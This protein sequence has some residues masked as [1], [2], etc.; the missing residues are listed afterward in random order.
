MKY[1][2]A[3]FF[4]GFVCSLSYSQ[5]LGFVK[6]KNKGKFYLYWG[7]NRGAYTDS[8]IHFK[9]SDYDF[10]LHDVKAQGSSKRFFSR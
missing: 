9:G 4:Y 7:W 8:D 1:I 3:V 5:E 10:V 2:L 6:P